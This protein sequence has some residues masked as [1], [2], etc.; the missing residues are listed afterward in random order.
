VRRWVAG[1]HT[2]KPLSQGL[3]GITRGRDGTVENTLCLI[4]VRGRVE[5]KAPNAAG[6]GAAATG[7]A[8]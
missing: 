5:G 8:A 3:G 1:L 6:L 7:G 2:L 4:G